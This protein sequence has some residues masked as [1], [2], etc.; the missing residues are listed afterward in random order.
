[1]R[2]E[3]LMRRYYVYKQEIKWVDRNKDGTVYHLSDWICLGYVETAQG[4]Y[5]YLG[6]IKLANS[7]DYDQ[8]NT[9]IQTWRFLLSN[10]Y[11]VTNEKGQIRINDELYK[12]VKK[13]FGRRQGRK[14][15][16]Y[17]W[18]HPNNHSEQTNTITPQ[19]IKEISNEYG[20]HL[21]QIKTKRKFNGWTMEYQTKMQRSWKR[22]RKHQY[23]G[24]KNGNVH[25]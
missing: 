4:V 17:R 24:T 25:K 20:I 6:E 19:E 7:F 22:Y 5:D 9:K 23:K 12:N 1:M 11:I 21:K 2:R 13:K 8:V 18:R 3:G 16:N 10:R 15:S 14:H